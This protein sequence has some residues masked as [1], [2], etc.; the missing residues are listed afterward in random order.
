M[1][2]LVVLIVGLASRA[3]PGVVGDL[4]GG[5]LY[6]VLLHCLIVFSAPTLRPLTAALAAFGLSTL[7]E[8]AQLTPLPAMLAAAFAPA[9]LV[10]GTTF[11]P[12]DFI[13]YALGAAVAMAVDLLLLSRAFKRA[14]EA[15]RDDRV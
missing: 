7:I 10:F 12:T 1:L 6:T 11:V 15:R 2:A 9:A 13:G 3:L 8:L 4:A 5:A 14:W